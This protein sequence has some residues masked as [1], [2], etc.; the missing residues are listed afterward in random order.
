MYISEL[1]LQGFKSFAHQTNLAFDNGVT[2]IVGPNGCGKSNIVD[3]LRWVLGEQRPT[4]LRS[5][6]MT[7]IIFNGS[8]Q[9]KALGM[10][11][12]LLTFV[13]N[14]GLLPTEYSEVTIGGACTDPGKVNI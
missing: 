14:K 13:N 10:A 6:N 12:V 4:L 8:E 3:S 1:K 5:V 9:K 2:A 7:N 11:E